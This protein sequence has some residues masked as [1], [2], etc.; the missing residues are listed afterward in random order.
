ML[1]AT[2]STTL[3]TPTPG[4]PKARSRPPP[5]SLTLTMA[6]VTASKNPAAK[7]IGTAQA[8][9]SSTNPIP[10]AT[11]PT[12]TFTSAASA[13]PTASLAA[14]ASITTA[15]ISWAPR[16]RF[17]RLRALSAM[18]QTS[19]PSAESARTPLL[20]RRRINSKAKNAT[21]K[22]ATTTSELATTPHPSAAGPRP[23][24]PQRPRRSRTPISP[25]PKP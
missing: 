24:G 3:T 20:A 25:T 22:P 6:T 9:K 13:S 5:V 7:S 16:A 1:P 14:T 19:T 23:I 8:P 10:P 11:S 4:T 21:P 2:P 15:K 18:T 12:S 17:S